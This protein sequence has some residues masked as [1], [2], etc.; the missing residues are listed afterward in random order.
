MT[1]GTGC[2]CLG[3]AIVKITIVGIST[4]VAHLVTTDECQGSI[5]VNL[6][7]LSDFYPAS[8]EMSP[9][10]AIAPIVSPTNLARALVESMIH[11]QLGHCP[12]PRLIILGRREVLPPT[13]EESTVNP[14]PLSNPDSEE[15]YLEEL[16]EYLYPKDDVEMDNNSTS[17]PEGIM[18]A[19]QQNAAACAGSVVPFRPNPDSPLFKVGDKRPAQDENEE[20]RKQKE[21]SPKPKCASM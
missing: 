1:E 10:L 18:P 21:E 9:N 3:G 13:M 6:C 20:H 12:R 4:I 2:G 16:E 11:K 14:V 5:I 15:E 19:P 8:G 17:R 7:H